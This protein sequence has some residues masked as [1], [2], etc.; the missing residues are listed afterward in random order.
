MTNFKGFASFV[1]AAAIVS[2]LSAETHCPGNAASVPL[3]LINRYQI[4][5]PVS[6][7]HSGPYNFVLDTGAE[8]TII[9]SS[10]AAELHLGTQGPAEI[11]S[12]GLRESSSLAQLDQ[13]AVGTQSLANQQVMVYDL[14]RLHSAD[15]PVRGILAVDFLGHFDLL[16]DNARKLLCLDDS[17]AMRAAVKGRHIPLVT[18]AGTADGAQAHGAYIL[19]VRLPGG[20]RPVL[21]KLD[22]G[23]NGAFLYNTSQ[24]L[25]RVMF[26][27]ASLQGRSV[28]GSQR[29]FSIL[30]PED[31]MIG[32]L[33]LPEVAFMTLVGAQKDSRT[34]AF[35]GLLPTNFFRLI[36]IN[37]ADHV[38]VLDPW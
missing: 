32:P 20:N 27:G 8:V 4:I 2:T 22:S 17:T 13:I 29:T 12:A 24:S 35:D 16:I 14:G 3:R 30:P 26:L 10:L 21:L 31:V 5:V 11:V 34:A 33:K 19:P 38:A 7:N 28:D 25:G 6:I 1:L 18:P 15:L 36:F 23:T 9:D 37:H